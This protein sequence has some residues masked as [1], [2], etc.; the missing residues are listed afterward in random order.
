MT[1]FPIK[2]VYIHQEVVTKQKPK[3]QVLIS[4]PKKRLRHAV[5]RNRTKRQIREA[6]RL[7]K[8]LLGDNESKVASATNAANASIAPAAFKVAF[9][10]LADTLID[11]WRVNQSM[12]NLLQRLTA[13]QP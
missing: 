1:A 7:N 9:I 6:Y 11:S 3:A 13:S 4:V 10:W 5:D 2:A 12:R 8:Y